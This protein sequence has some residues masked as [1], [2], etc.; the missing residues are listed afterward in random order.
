M[1]CV[2]YHVL[3]ALCIACIMCDVALASS[4]IGL[5]G[6]RAPPVVAVANVTGHGYNND[7]G[8]Y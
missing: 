4:V 5:G 1:I 7:C 6:L 2:I 8:K 3:L